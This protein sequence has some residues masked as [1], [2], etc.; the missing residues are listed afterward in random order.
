MIFTSTL[1]AF[2]VISCQIGLFKFLY[3]TSSCSHDK[4]ACV[5]VGAVLLQTWF[6]TRSLDEEMSVILRMLVV[7]RVIQLCN[8]IGQVR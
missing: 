6:D 7:L 4:I 1:N 8:F 5:N 3:E 2:N